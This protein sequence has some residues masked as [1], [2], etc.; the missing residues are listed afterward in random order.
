MNLGAD[1]FW[2]LALMLAGCG[3]L[4][5]LAWWWPLAGLFLYLASV[6]LDYLLSAAGFTTNGLFS[7]GQATLVILAAVSLAKWRL[8][9]GSFPPL[10]RGF[11]RRIWFFVVAA[12]MSAFFGIWPPNSLFKA[13]VL[14]ATSFI[15]FVL[16]VLIDRP[17]RLEAAL[18]CIGL[19]VTLSAMIGCLQYAG[20]LSSVNSE[21]QA[22]SE[23]KRGVVMEYRANGGGSVEGARYAGPTGNANG[24]G[25]VLM[26]GIPALFYLVTSRR[27]LL[28]R[29]TAA[30]ALGISGFALVL[31]MSRTHIC[32]F[33]LYLALMM[34]FNKHPNWTRRIFVWLMALLACGGFLY[35]LSQMEG[36]GDR[37]KAGLEQGDDSSDTR[38]GVMWG[39]LRAWAAH[40]LVGIGLNNT[41]VAGYNET[42][43]ASHDIISTLFGEL[44]GLGALAFAL[45]AWQAFK[46]LPSRRDCLWR[47]Q[48]MLAAVSP[49]VKA[50]LL[51]CL[52]CGFG[53]PVIDGRA[54]W[55]W[56]GLCAVLHRLHVADSEAPNELNASESP[57]SG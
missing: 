9:R 32:G 12:L 53:D 54:F 17:G 10:A 6:G 7:I 42:G 38:L 28:Q 49:P 36:V 16:Y 18:W 45:I 37:L 21:Q 3:T 25:V 29:T 5:L 50:A 31:T 57:I 48:T 15:P 8:Q 35:A 4:T 24:F 34:A 39:G 43:N 13:L 11:F 30:A 2:K 19:G 40:P 41:D 22:M 46:L 33:L 1:N 47:G 52:I 23:D 20:V 14:M 44:G 26:G 55:I 51:A 56:I 27:S